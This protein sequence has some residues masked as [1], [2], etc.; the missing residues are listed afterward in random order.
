MLITEQKTIQIFMLFPVLQRGQKCRNLR[1]RWKLGTQLTERLKLLARQRL[2]A[3][4]NVN[5]GQVQ[6]E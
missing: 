1:L 3:A 5:F 2:L 4:L 6:L